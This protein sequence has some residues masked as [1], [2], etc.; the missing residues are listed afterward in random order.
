[1]LLLK[2]GKVAVLH[3]AARYRTRPRDARVACCQHYDIKDFAAE[4][5]S[6]E[7]PAVGLQWLEFGT[8]NEV[9]ARDAPLSTRFT[10]RFAVFRPEVKTMFL[11]DRVLSHNFPHMPVLSPLRPNGKMVKIAVGTAAPGA[12]WYPQVR[13]A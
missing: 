8:N 1:M 11:C 3:R 7:F 13:A 4:Y 2:R 9:F 5:M 12:A 10:S 6:S